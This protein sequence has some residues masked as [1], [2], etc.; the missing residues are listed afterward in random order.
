MFAVHT[1]GA[2]FTNLYSF[3]YAPMINGIIPTAMEL[4][5]MPD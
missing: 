5:R 3:T 4:I 1:D 2:G